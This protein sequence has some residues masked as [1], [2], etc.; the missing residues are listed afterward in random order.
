MSETRQER[1]VNIL[2]IPLIVRAMAT[3]KN[4][5]KWLTCELKRAKKLHKKIEVNA[6]RIAESGIYLSII[7]WIGVDTRLDRYPALEQRNSFPDLFY[8]Q[9]PHILHFDR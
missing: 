8:F 1:I 7:H 3:T 9:L 5:S 2:I 4:G 6:K